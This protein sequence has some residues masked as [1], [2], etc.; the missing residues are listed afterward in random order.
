MLEGVRFT[1]LGDQV[2]CSGTRN[3]DIVKAACIFA[4]INQREGANF[5]IINANM[6]TIDV[7]DNLL[8]GAGEWIGTV[9]L[10]RGDREWVNS[11]AFKMTVN[12]GFLPFYG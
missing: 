12:F 11:V 3:I 10:C 4:I 5:S 1:N 6:P 2:K 7:G 9:T 8:T